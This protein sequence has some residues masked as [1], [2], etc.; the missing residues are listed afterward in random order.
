MNPNSVRH[1]YP[2]GYDFGGLDITLEIT[3]QFLQKPTK[4]QV[5][6]VGNRVLL[7][8][9]MRALFYATISASILTIFMSLIALRLEI[10]SLT[11]FILV[12]TFLITIII[13]SPT[14]FGIKSSNAREVDS[15]G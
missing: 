2:D 12:M 6:D 4:K 15:N 10:I 3:D 1:E 9:R 13:A 8:I 14:I 11:E 7:S 5:H